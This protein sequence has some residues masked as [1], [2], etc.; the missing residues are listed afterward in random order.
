MP[1]QTTPQPSRDHVVDCEFAD[2]DVLVVV[3]VVVAAAAAGAV[4]THWRGLVRDSFQLGHA[5][6]S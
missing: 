3:V 1:Y 4:D 2:D 5:K 6:A